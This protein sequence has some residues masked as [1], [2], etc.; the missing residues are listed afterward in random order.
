VLVAYADGRTMT[1]DALPVATDRPDGSEPAPPPNWPDAD[2][3]D[4]DGTARGDC[5]NEVVT[6]SYTPQAP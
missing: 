3:E 2:D 6:S 1:I 5:A 4:N